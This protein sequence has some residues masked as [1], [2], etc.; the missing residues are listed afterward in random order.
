MGNTTF[1]R[2][3]FSVVA[4]EYANLKRIHMNFLMNGEGIYFK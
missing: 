1:L 3:R 4:L 2:I